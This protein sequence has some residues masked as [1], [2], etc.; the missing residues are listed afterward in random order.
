MHRV[1]NVLIAGSDP[2]F[3]D[4]L[5]NGLSDRDYTTLAYDSFEDVRDEAEGSAPDLIVIDCFSEDFDGF[6]VARQLS[7]N[8]MT[9]TI[10]LI[11]AVRDGTGETLKKARNVGGH[12]ALPV[13]FKLD[14]LERRIRP[15]LRLSTMYQEL[16][17][18]V[19]L[20]KKYQLD[21]AP[22][23][24]FDEQT[25]KF[26]ILIVNRPAAEET[27]LQ[28]LLD[29]RG[30]IDVCDDI[31]QAD[32][33]L[34]SAF[35]DCLVLGSGTDAQEALE[36]CSR[37][38]SNSR[39]FNLPVVLMTPE[40]ETLDPVKA[41]G[42][43]ATMV[44]GEDDDAAIIHAIVILSR[45]QQLRWKIRQ[46]M[47]LVLKNDVLDPLTGLHNFEFLSGNLSNLIV[48]AQEWHKSLTVVFF[49]FSNLPGLRRQ[50][51]DEAANHM[52]RQLGTWINSLVR[53]EDMVSRYGDQDFCVYLPD[54]PIAVA[55]AVMSRIAGILSSTEFSAQEVYQPLNVAVAMGMAELKTN[56]TVG[57]PC[58]S[59]PF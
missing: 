31:Q 39:L 24:A 25:E 49:S 11:L 29:N 35:Y 59:R 5:V 27:R 2:D 42:K 41:Y 46:K 53:A 1:A 15:L 32:S 10:P 51:G 6:E 34:E 55:Q 26:K 56:D 43:G 36:L 12:D 50:F 57:K 23:V 16:H 33:H 44:V 54:T 30:D 18:R 22:A 47:D 7:S 3:L 21:I 19:F 9:S 17:R 40:G 8:D 58:R 13:P 52:L 38:R 20:G 28:L 14:E 4:G 45:R 48:T 37:L